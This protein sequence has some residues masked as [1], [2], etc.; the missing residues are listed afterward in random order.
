MFPVLLFLFE[1][2]RC[3]IHAKARAGRAGAVRENMPQVRIALRTQGFYAPHAMTSIGFPAHFTGVQRCGETGPS[4]TRFKLGGASEQ[5]RA[6]AH[7]AVDAIFV[8]IPIL[9]RESRLGSLLPS[10]VI[11]LWG[12]L[13]APLFFCFLNFFHCTSSLPDGFCYVDLYTGS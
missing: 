8:V 5:L 13:F 10:H 12:Q 7:A 1:I 9:A 11:L 2:E 4:R 3:R 6:A